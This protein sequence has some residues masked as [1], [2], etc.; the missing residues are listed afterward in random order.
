[1]TSITLKE[2][3]TG[4]PV[5]NGY[6]VSDGSPVMGDVKDTGSE[7]STQPARPVSDF[8]QAKKKNGYRLA[9]NGDEENAPFPAPAS[10]K[11]ADEFL[12]AVFGEK[13]QFMHERV[14]DGTRKRLLNG[15]L[16]PAFVRAH[17]EALEKQQ[18]AFGGASH[19]R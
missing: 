16:T 7:A 2:Y 15:I 17:L 18:P 11:E 1:M 6:E 3:L 5:I 4:L 13:L 12:S 19:A 9:A 8:N 10:E 14:L